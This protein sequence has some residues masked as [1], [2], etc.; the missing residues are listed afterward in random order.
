MSP[1][2]DLF[3]AAHVLAIQMAQQANRQI[4]TCEMMILSC[5]GRIQQRDQRIAVD[6]FLETLNEPIR[7]VA[8]I[9]GDGAKDFPCFILNP[10]S[11][12][13]AE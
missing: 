11:K 1:Q 7:V 13:L 10:V 6:E 5:P 9:T 12:L 2:E 8:C 3:P 4:G